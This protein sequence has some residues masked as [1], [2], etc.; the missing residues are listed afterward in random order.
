[1]RLYSKYTKLSDNLSVVEGPGNVLLVGTP[2]GTYAYLSKEQQKDPKYLQFYPPE[3]FKRFVPLE[4]NVHTLPKIPTQESQKAWAESGVRVVTHVMRSEDDKVRLVFG[5]TEDKL[6]ILVVASEGFRH[7][8]NLD[9]GSVLQGFNTHTRDV[10]VCGI[11]H[12]EQ[13]AAKLSA[14]SVVHKPCEDSVLG[15]SRKA[16][17]REYKV[18]LNKKRAEIAEKLYTGELKR[19][20]IGIFKVLDGLF[21]YDDTTTLNVLSDNHKKEIYDKLASVTTDNFYEALYAICCPEF[22]ISSLGLGVKLELEVSGTALSVEMRQGADRADGSASP[23]RRYI[24]DKLITQDDYRPVLERVT[25]YP[26]ATEA[27]KLYVEQVACISLYYHGLNEDGMDFHLGRADSGN[28]LLARAYEELEVPKKDRRADVPEVSEADYVFPI[29]AY[30]SHGGGNNGVNR[31][32][33][34]FSVNIPFRKLK[35]SQKPQIFLLGKW[36]T[37]AKGASVVK[38]LVGYMAKHGSSNFGQRKDSLPYDLRYALDGLKIKPKNRDVRGSFIVRER[39]INTPERTRLSERFVRIADS[40][41]ENGSFITCLMSYLYT[42][43][44]SLVPEDKIFCMGGVAEGV[45]LSLPEGHVDR[46]YSYTPMSADKAEILFDRFLPWWERAIKH[47]ISPLAIQASDQVVAVGDA[48]KKSEEILLSAIK[49]TKAEHVK[50]SRKHYAKVTGHSGTVYW[51]CIN[52]GDVYLNARKNEK[53]EPGQH[54]CI[55]RASNAEY[56]G[57]DYVA[58]LVFALHSD[59]RTAKQIYT[60]DNL[61]K[62]PKKTK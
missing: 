15:V 28:V 4:T 58:S 9:P 3:T 26:A 54:I 55:V 43:D 51:I 53:D 36:R 8:N 29:P 47:V 30:K 7:F 57:H 60:I 20:N 50:M 16:S 62:K 31:G 32:G 10:T 33:S 25:C 22:I 19:G 37:L 27:Y 11:G 23:V 34:E 18:E 52:D 2:G 35:A 45:D 59:S 12:W 21:Y 48:L 46:N 24:N 1:M 39:D 41:N 49:Q 5:G 14:A 42:I 6:P 44:Q 56:A 38:S 61:L 17:K 13:N 40:T